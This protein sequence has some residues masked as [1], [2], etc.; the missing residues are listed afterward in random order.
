MNEDV[1]FC[2]F[3]GLE[4]KNTANCSVDC[5]IQ[6]ETKEMLFSEK[7]ALIKSKGILISHPPIWNLTSEKK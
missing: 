1:C 6:L 5:G 7:H 3:C 2:H 4:I